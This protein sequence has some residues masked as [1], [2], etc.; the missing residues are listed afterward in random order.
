MEARALSLAGIAALALSALAVLPAQAQTPDSLQSTWILP[1]PNEDPMAIANVQMVPA[2]SSNSATAFGADWGVAYASTYFQERA[3]GTDRSDGTATVGLGFGDA[4]KWVGMEVAVMSL[5]TVR[6]FG[7]FT[8]NVK[9]HRRLPGRAA[10]AVGIEHAAIIGYTDSHR[11]VFGV[12]TKQFTF[13]DSPKDWFSSLTASLGAGN[14]RYVS[15]KD[16]KAKNYDRVNAF[17]SVSMRVAEPMA[18]VADWT[19]QDLVLGLSLVPFKKIPL[20]ISPAF[21]DV[22]R[23][24]NHEPRFVLAAGVASYL[25]NL[26][27]WR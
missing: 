17:G 7:R 11:S 8:L 18:F 15:D 3:R 20:V 4:R 1:Y 14:G 2:S 26:F 9:A 6:S 22:M 21:A 19:G 5:G 23:I 10:V 27:S 12:A 25:P 24:A 13:R 16:W